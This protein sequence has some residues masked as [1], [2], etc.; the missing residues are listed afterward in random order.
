[1]STSI[2][3]INQR[4][5]VIAAALLAIASLGL[6]SNALAC[7]GNQCT[8]MP[9]V[10]WDEGRS[11]LVYGQFQVGSAQEGVGYHGTPSAGNV[12]EQY[13]TS[14]GFTEG[15]GNLEADVSSCR[16]DECGG[17]R[18]GFDG[19]AVGHNIATSYQKVNGGPAAAGSTSAAA[20][21]LQAHGIVVRGITTQ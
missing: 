16:S 11:V 13:A 3:N 18:V 9:S 1:M 5:L 12:A 4:K 6:A 15:R 7:G 14:D 19:N 2:F 10:Q 21:A 17:M 8:P 20:G